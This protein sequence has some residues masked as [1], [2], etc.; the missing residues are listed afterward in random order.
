MG[1]RD[2]PFESCNLFDALRIRNV[3]TRAAR[4]KADP[5]RILS[6]DTRDQQISS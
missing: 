5:N 4:I 6:A 1:H 3:E 2:C